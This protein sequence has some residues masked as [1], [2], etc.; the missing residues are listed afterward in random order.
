MN[1]ASA[2]VSHR[3][4]WIIKGQNELE[5]LIYGRAHEFSPSSSKHPLRDHVAGGAHLIVNS[6]VKTLL[7]KLYS[8]SFA[9][10]KHKSVI[11]T[12]D[13]NFKYLFWFYKQ[14]PLVE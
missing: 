11:S 8:S 6:G 7:L 3:H 9:A 5:R 14:L 10:T 2:A 1:P 13:Q 12:R 4:C